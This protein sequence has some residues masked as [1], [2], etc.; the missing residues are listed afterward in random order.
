MTIPSGQEQIPV[1]R[2]P[3]ITMALIAVSA[4]LF[5]LSHQL[6]QEQLPQIADVKTHILMLAA[7]NP[8]LDIT[9]EVRQFVSNF[10]EHNPEKWRFL[11]QEFRPVADDWDARTRDITNQDTLQEEMN[12]LVGEYQAFSSDSFSERF[13]FLPS[14]PQAPAYITASF[15]YI[16]RAQLIGV[17]CVLLLAGIVLEDAWGRVIFIAIFCAASAITMQLHSWT[18]PA[19][20][21]PVVGA[22]G[23]VALF[24]GAVL[25]RFP[26]RKVW[27]FGPRIRAI[28]FAPVWL[29]VEAFVKRKDLSGD[30]AKLS[31]YPNP[32]IQW[33]VVGIAFALGA[34]IAILFRFLRV[35]RGSVQHRIVS[36]TYVSAPSTLEAERLMDEGNLKE[37]ESILKNALKKDPWAVDALAVLSQ[38]YWRRDEIQLSGDTTVKLIQAYLKLRDWKEAWRTYEDYLNSGGT[39]IP[40]AVWVE[41]CR[42]ADDEHLYERAVQECERLITL[43]P[44]TR[45]ALSAQLR[46]AKI[47]LKQLGRPE[48][49]LQLYEAAYASPIPHLDFEQAI[50]TGIRESKVAISLAGAFPVR[51]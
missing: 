4:V 33:I 51:D 22:S 9:P 40:A 19:S 42:I 8:G 39:D 14:S 28:W 50:E 16:D 6:M 2:W 31:I 21:V 15:F 29:A 44:D 27:L 13:T 17:L 36:K 48:R 26:M 1:R 34:L 7:R 10:S 49:A 18:D 30:Y 38:L 32:K 35:E 46:A 37:A 5:F 11:Q 43:F 24:M 3:I 23:V 25:V 47:Y 45:E 20:I 12:G 41:L